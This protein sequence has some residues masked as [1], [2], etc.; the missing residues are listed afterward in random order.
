MMAEMQKKY[1]TRNEYYQDFYKN[2]K[3]Y[4]TYKP[5]DHYKEFMDRKAEEEKKVK[6]ANVRTSLMFYE[7]VEA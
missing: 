7:S 1:E 6:E 5:D 2:V 4:K 3:S